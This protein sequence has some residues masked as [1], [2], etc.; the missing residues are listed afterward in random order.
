MG[1]QNA[2]KIGIFGIERIFRI[3]YYSYINS[4][5]IIKNESH[6]CQKGHYPPNVL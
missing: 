6:E 5:H 2:Q 4:E 1:H 3:L